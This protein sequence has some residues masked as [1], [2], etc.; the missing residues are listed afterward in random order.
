MIDG[1]VFRW[2]WFGSCRRPTTHAIFQAPDIQLKNLGSANAL[3][4]CMAWPNDGDDK[5]PDVG[6]D[7][8]VFESDTSYTN[9]LAGK[10]YVA[11]M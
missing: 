10:S 11:R 3:S 2:R 8:T 1:K 5:A 4:G 9:A 6:T 7:I